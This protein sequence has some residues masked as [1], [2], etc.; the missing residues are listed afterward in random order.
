MVSIDD[1]WAK[2]PVSGDDITCV[3]VEEFDALYA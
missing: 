2:E 3:D 1:G